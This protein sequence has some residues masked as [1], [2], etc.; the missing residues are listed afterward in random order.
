MRLTPYFRILS[1]NWDIFFGSGPGPY[2]YTKVDIQ[3][4]QAFPSRKQRA[5]VF[6]RSLLSCGTIVKKISWVWDWKSCFSGVPSP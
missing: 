2:Q 5:N 1:E 3:F 6:G 4:R